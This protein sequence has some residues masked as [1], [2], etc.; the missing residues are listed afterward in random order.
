MKFRRER[1]KLTPLFSTPDSPTPPPYTTMVW[2]APSTMLARP[3]APSAMPAQWSTPST[4][5]MVSQLSATDPH[6]LF[7]TPDSPTPHSPE[8]TLCTTLLVSSTPSLTPTTPLLSLLLS[9]TLPLFSTLSSTTLP[10]SRPMIMVL[11]PPL[12]ELSTLPMLESASTMKVPR[13]PANCS[14]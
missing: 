14:I 7:S 13:F 4:T 10:L 5:T 3:S 9:T 6:L 8:S 2:S 11:P 1:L 12:L